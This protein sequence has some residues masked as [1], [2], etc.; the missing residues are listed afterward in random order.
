MQTQLDEARAA[1]EPAAL[2]K[3]ATDRAALIASAKAVMPTL[4]ASGKTAADIR[5]EVVTAKLGDKAPT[6][7]A[8][9][10]GAF[11]VLTA[12]PVTDSTV[13]NI[14]PAQPANLTDSRSAV[15]ALRIARYS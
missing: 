3:L 6:A 15:N 7:D 14:A 1:I 11:A 8:A 13:H 2:D 12:S 4:D 10:E 5:K 9:I